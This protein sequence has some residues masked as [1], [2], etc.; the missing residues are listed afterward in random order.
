[1]ETVR[2]RGAQKEIVRPLFPG[3]LFVHFQPDAGGW[4]SINS[5][6]GI[7]RLLFNDVRCPRPLP[8][9]FMAGL[10]ARCDVNGMLKPPEDLEVDDRI[11]VISGPFADLVTTVEKMD[12]DQRL[13]VLIDLMGRAV[14]VT[15]PRESVERI[16]P[17]AGTLEQ[18]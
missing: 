12:K 9:Q 4:Q 14:R 13:Q 11:R 10:I 17:D 6:R 15:V 3:Y 16:M 18:G 7:S 1:M 2:I 8:V 5:T